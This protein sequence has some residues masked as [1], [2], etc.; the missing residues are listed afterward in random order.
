MPH[1]FLAAMRALGEPLEPYP[2]PALQDA[3]GGA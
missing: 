1:L 3:H 2:E